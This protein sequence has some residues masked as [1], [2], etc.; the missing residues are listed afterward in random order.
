M[1]KE[2]IPPA[3]FEELKKK[4]NRARRTIYNRI[5][6]KVKEYN[7]TINR[8]TGSFLVA[9][10]LDINFTKYLTEQDKEDLRKANAYIQP[11]I[12]GKPQIIVRK[13]TKSLE[14]LKGIS[15]IDPF[16]PS[17]LLDEATEMAEKVY[18]FLYIFENS[19]RNVIKTF[20]ETKYGIDWWETRVKQL[21]SNIDREVLKRMNQEK[22]D[23]W[24]ATK[25]GIHKIYYTDLND[26]NI[27]I[28]DNWPVFK[29]LHNRKTWVIEHIMQL[30]YSRNIIA[31]NNRLKSRDII[32]IQT[33]IREWFDQ[34]K[35]LQV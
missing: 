24:A 11:V 33:K 30:K 29:K 23:R 7:G 1:R 26:L 16:L 2:N 13:E 3:L 34:I 20:M 14:P 12:Q 18:P 22:Q 15:S 9:K 19:I 35:D 6:N 27:I 28:D 17:S 10:D 25:R 31:H 21:H 8:R 5:L 32:S 4:A